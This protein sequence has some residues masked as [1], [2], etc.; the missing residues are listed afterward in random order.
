MPNKLKFSTSKIAFFLEK[1]IA[2]VVKEAADGHI[3]S[4]S[5]RIKGYIQT[6]SSDTQRDI[7]CALRAVGGQLED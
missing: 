4:L 7:T 3:S 2:S 5:E 1:W 6:S